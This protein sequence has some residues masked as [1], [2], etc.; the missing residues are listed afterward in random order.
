MAEHLI[1]HS[2][3]SEQLR[4]NYPDYPLLYARRGDLKEYGYAAVSHWHPDLEYIYINEGIMDYFV[5][6]EIVRMRSGEGIFVNSSRLHYGFSKENY[7]CKFLCIVIHPEVFT[8]GTQAGRDYVDRKFSAN[9][10]DYI[11]LSPSVPWQEEL[12]GKL[13]KFYA[14]MHENHDHLLE[15]MSQALQIVDL[16]GQHIPDA[17]KGDPDTR[18]LDSFLQMTSYVAI[19]YPEKISLDEMAAAGA[20]SR[21]KACRLFQRFAQ[22]TPGQYLQQ[23]RVEKSAVL[24]RD[25]NLPVSEISWRCGFSSPSYYTSVF[26]EMKDRTP[27][28]YR[29]FLK[30]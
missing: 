25:T 30:N 6:G 3:L 17:P 14:A 27:K 7:D 8:Q 12:L 22:Q 9:N 19:H 20:V 23:Y 13:V 28:E 2:D 10:P 1:V 24:L 4:Y 16:T 11:F 29:K 26:R 18:G 5:N 21:S 15:A